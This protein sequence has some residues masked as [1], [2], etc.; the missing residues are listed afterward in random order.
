[1]CFHTELGRNNSCLK[2]YNILK[3]KKSF[4]KCNNNSNQGH[5]KCVSDD[6]VLKCCQNLVKRVM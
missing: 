4:M 3:K 1:M 5:R 6:F 2:L